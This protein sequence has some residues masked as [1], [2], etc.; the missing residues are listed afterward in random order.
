M[1]TDEQIKAM[2]K[3][4]ANERMDGLLVLKGHLGDAFN[5]TNLANAVATAEVQSYLDRRVIAAQRYARLIPINNTIPASAG[6]VLRRGFTNAV[7]IGK[8]HAGSGKDIPLADVLYGDSIISIDMGTIGYQYSIGEMESASR[9]NVPLSSD[10]IS[11]ARLGF[12]KHMYNVA[13]VGDAETGKEGLLNNSGVVVSVALG[14]WTAS[15][16]PKQMVSD[17][18]N[19][20]SIA[21]EGVDLTGDVSLLPDTFLLPTNV[22]ILLNDTYMSELSN[23]SVLDH[24][25]EKNILTVSGVP[26]VTFEPLPELATMGA[27]GGNRIVIYLKDPSVVEFILP[28]DLTFLPP[29]PEGVEVFTPGWYVYG[30]TW[31]KSK[32]SFIYLDGI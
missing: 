12:E 25:K 18:S 28:K 24:I 14:R 32:E 29:Q 6:D 31:V 26:D 13:M 11:A 27:D 4:I 8:R 23:V 21:F 30:G 7:G 16:P 9:A 10:K 1:F 2:I 22:F 5:Q 19:A 15:T 20:I 17:I 3:S